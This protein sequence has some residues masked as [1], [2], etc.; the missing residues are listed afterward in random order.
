MNIMNVVRKSASFAAL[1]VA[2]SGSSSYAADDLPIVEGDTWSYFK[3]TAEPTT[4]IGDLLWAQIGFDDSS[5]DTGP[6]GFGYS[7]SDDNT[8]L[9]DME[10]P[11]SGS[12]TPLNGTGYLSVYIRR[13]F[14]ID[15]P[16]TVTSLTL[17]VDYDDGYVCYINGTEVARGGVA[18]TPPAFNVD[19]S[20]PGHEAGTPV[21]TSPSVSLL[22]A[23]DNVLAC[24]GHNYLISSSDFS[25]IPELSATE[26]GP[27]PI[28]EGDDWRYFVGTQEPTPWANPPTWAQTAF[29]DTGWLEGPSG[30]GYGTDCPHGTTIDIRPNVSLYTRRAFSIDDAGAV[31]SLTLTTD[32]DDGWVAY[33]NGVEIARSPGMGGT[34]GVPPFYNDTTTTGDHECSGASVPNPPEDFDLDI[35]ELLTGKNVLAIQAHNRSTTS[36]D[37]TIIATLSAVI[38]V[39]TPDQPVLVAPSPT[40]VGGVSVNPTLE[41]TVSDPD[42]DL[43][44][45][46]F[47][48][49]EDGEV[50]G[51]NFSIIHF[52]DTQIYSQSYP[53]IFEGMT[54]WIVDNE[55]PWNIVYAGHQ[56]DIVNVSTTTQWDNVDTA[57]S[58]LETGGIPYG[59]S[60]GNHDG[61]PSSTGLF[62]TYFGTSRFSGQPYYGGHYGS[63]N[64]NNYTLFSG[65]GMDFIVI[66]LEMVGNSST[67]DAAVL[68]WADDLLTTYSDR[69]AIVISHYLINLDNSW[70]TPGL[71]IY[72][73]L[74]DNPNLF[75]MLCGHMHGEARRTDTR[76]GM[77]DVYTLLGDY[78]D[79]TYGG[80][81]RMRIL[82][83]SPLNDEIRVYTYSSETGMFDTD[84]DSEFVLPCAMNDGAPF[85]NLGTVSG[86]TSG[87]NAQLTTW[88]GLTPGAVH[89]WYVEVT[90]GTSTTTGPTWTFTTE[91]TV[92]EDCEDDN[93]CTDDSCNAGTCEY[94]NNTEPCNDGDA[95]TETDTCSGGT[96]SGTAV[97]CPAGQSCD[98]AASI[99]LSDPVTVSFQQGTDGY[100]GAVDTYC[101]SSTPTTSYGG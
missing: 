49:R 18:G 61:A 75:L 14:N 6:S 69:R 25:L 55:V 41:V 44:D 73:A 47:Y 84:A 89:E 12:G 32:Y 36:S 31:S 40:G 95:C 46:T 1:V 2:L 76:T 28:V 13:V 43:L 81:G 77:E 51:E 85:V 79:Y 72:N 19:A 78:Q 60:P 88:S 59:V 15:N 37:F 58:I 92:V 10:G 93:P 91:C 62:N 82:E 74:K 33:L 45:V 71:A 35:G 63:D 39:G 97:T 99:C 54:Q 96:C 83:F 52:P 3:G 21:V 57:L 101:D 24:Q 20:A 27:L 87:S 22:V 50:G 48:G 70:G 67:P 86:V 80:N 38:T 16:G 68:A 42:F 7:D 56:G 9:T 23:G 30:F 94:T 90:D 17:S 65:G 34:V 98:P 100:A 4:P 29:D 66:A 8:L 26:L 11:P 64:D 5:W 53:A